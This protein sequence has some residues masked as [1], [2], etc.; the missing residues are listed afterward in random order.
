MTDNLAP[1]VV[2]SLASPGVIR[3]ADVVVRKGMFT[4]VNGHLTPRESMI[5]DLLFLGS[6]LD[7]AEI[8][9]FLIRD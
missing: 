7:S 9:F 2:S 1:V 6:V 3:R 5:E 8:P 4:L